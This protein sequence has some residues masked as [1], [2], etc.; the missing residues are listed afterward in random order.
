MEI[1]ITGGEEDGVDN[2]GMDQNKLYTQPEQVCMCARFHRSL[3]TL[4]FPRLWRY[5]PACGGIPP[6]VAARFAPHE[7]E[8]GGRLFT[9]RRKDEL[10]YLALL[11]AACSST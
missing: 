2:T 8:Q 9:A 4:P 3:G 1:G 7:Q 5:S 6:L 10:D 11:R